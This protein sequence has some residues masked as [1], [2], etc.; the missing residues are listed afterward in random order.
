MNL[1]VNNLSTRIFLIYHL[2]TKIL[3]REQN[4][5]LMNSEI[6]FLKKWKLFLQLNLESKQKKIP[7]TIFRIFISIHWMNKT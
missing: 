6:F 3:S 4:K 2:S 5:P 1:S 7:Q